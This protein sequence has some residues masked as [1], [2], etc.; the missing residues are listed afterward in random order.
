MIVTVTANPAIDR[1]CRLAVLRPGSLHRTTAVR[2]EPSGKGVNVGRVLHRLGLPARMVVTAGGAE[3]RMLADLLA[4]LPPAPHV[5]LVPVVGS[6]RVNITVLGDGEPTKI[7]EP[8]SA[9]SPVEADR[10]VATVADTLAAGD[11]RWLACCGS[12][13]AGT[14]PA[15]ITK[16]VE[17]ARRTGVPVAVDAS[18]A[19]LAAAVA[20]CADLVTPN[21]DELAEL[22]G[23]PLDTFP[24][25]VAAAREIRARTGGSVLVSLGADGA[26]L[27]TEAGGYRRLSARRRWPGR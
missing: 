23:W 13:P 8:S 17:V 18:G 2:V 14:D 12:L 26:L 10:I 20:A 6:T 4:Q 27:L 3:G 11:V 21:R 24:D 19:A 9:L 25:S 1:T 5:D 16:L 15:L 7:N 22:V